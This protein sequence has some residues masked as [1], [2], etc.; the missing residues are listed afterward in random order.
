M[1]RGRQLGAKVAALAAFAAGFSGALALYSRGLFSYATTNPYTSS[2][3]ILVALVG[4]LVGVIGWRAINHPDRQILRQEFK[5]LL[6][7]YLGLV[8]GLTVP[9]FVSNPAWQSD[10]SLGSGPSATNSD[11]DLLAG[12]Q[13]TI[14]RLGGNEVVESGAAAV[15]A[16]E[17]QKKHSDFFLLEATGASFSPSRCHQLADRGDISLAAG[18]PAVL[19]G[20]TLFEEGATDEC[21]FAEVASW[22]SANPSKNLVIAYRGQSFGGLESLAG[23]FS[24]VMDQVIVQSSSPELLDQAVLAGFD[25]VM[26]SLAESGDFESMLSVGFDVP[27]PFAVSVPV[28]NLPNLDLELLDGVPVYAEVVNQVELLPSVR[29]MGASGIVT[30]VISTRLP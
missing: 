6:A 25:N 4:A 29:Q 7:A 18:E 11:R 21:L 14:M 22:L 16:L 28:D 26:V 2:T 15:T 12:W 1:L 30:D 17:T 10:Q 24:E 20:E 9:A 19:G 8:L 23:V 5:L 13:P 3:A 27:K